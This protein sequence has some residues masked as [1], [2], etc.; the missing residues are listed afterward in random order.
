[1][2]EITFV[3]REPAGGAGNFEYTYECF[4]GVPRPKT[5]VV[6]TAGND[7]E[8]RRLAQTECDQTCNE[9]GTA[10]RQA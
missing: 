1:M 9:A 7:N 2:G 10:S 6:V 5:T 3:K 4:C 8:G